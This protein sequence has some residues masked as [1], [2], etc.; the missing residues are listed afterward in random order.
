MQVSSIAN[1]YMQ[2]ESP[3]EAKQFSSGRS[4]TVIYVLV[5]LIRFISAL[6]EPYIPTTSAKIN[7]LLG[8]N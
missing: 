8:F 2:D 1:K 7:F 5:N 3:W 6:L 4:Q